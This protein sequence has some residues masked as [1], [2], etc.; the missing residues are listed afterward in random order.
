MPLSKADH[1]EYMRKRNARIRAEFFTGKSCVKCGSTDSLEL[2]HIDP[3]QKV[4]H[5]IWSWSAERRATE[6]AKCQV[7]CADCHLTKTKADRRARMK[8]GTESMYRLGC[9]CEPCRDAKRIARARRIARTHE[10]E[11]AA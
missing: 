7:L 4:G 10:M 3:A 9:R 2:D 1:A 5:R 6:I 8:H 11:Q